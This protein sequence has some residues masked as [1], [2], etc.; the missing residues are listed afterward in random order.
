MSTPNLEAYSTALRGARDELFAMIDRDNWNPI[1]LRLAWQLV[2][3]FL[4]APL[5]YILVLPHDRTLRVSFD[6]F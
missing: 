4:N 5:F 6:R 3:F 1:L 2:F